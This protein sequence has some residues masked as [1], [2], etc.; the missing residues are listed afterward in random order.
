MVFN[1][2][3]RLRNQ[4]AQE[5]VVDQDSPVDEE[6]DD[7]DNEMDVEFPQGG[8]EEEEESADN[9]DLD[10]ASESDP[11]PNNPNSPFPCST[12]LHDVEVELFPC[13]TGPNLDLFDLDYYANPIDFFNLYIPDS[14][15]TQA[16]EQTNLY[17]S[18]TMG[19][20]TLF[21]PVTVDDISKYF[22]INMMFGIHKLPS[23]MKICLTVKK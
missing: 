13:R 10:L 23:H 20:Q 11:N 9:V 8:E 3:I 12:T 6:E 4:F 2:F 15:I 14:F 19:A 17:S 7:I 21:K 22:Y 5:E 18:Q 1:F 16:A